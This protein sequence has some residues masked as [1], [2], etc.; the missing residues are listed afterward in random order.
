MIQF[1]IDEDNLLV[2]VHPEGSLQKDDFIKLA[3]S[4]DALIE[5]KGK[6]SGILIET[7]SFP[8][9]ESVA[10]MIEHFKFIKNHHQKIKKV[11]LVTNTKLAHIAE[12]FASHFIS[13]E[14]KQFPYEDKKSARDWIIT[15]DK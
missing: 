11:A 15:S 1:D 13:A 9:W 7:E 8:G 5:K 2:E 3:S 14:I 10:A 12:K 6:L 4:V